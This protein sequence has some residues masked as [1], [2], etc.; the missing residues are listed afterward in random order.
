MCTRPPQ[1]TGE[2]ADNNVYWGLHINQKCVAVPNNGIQFRIKSIMI[3]LPTLLQIQI[4]FRC[5]LFT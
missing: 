5:D 2:E 3:S 1:Y 4:S